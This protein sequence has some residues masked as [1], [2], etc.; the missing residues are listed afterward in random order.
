VLFSFGTD[1]VALGVDIGNAASLNQPIN[2]PIE[3]QFGG[4]VGIV[5]C[6][7]VRRSRAGVV[8]VVGP[9]V[10]MGSSRARRD[11]VATSRDGTFENRSGLALDAKM[12]SGLCCSVL[13]SAHDTGSQ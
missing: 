4:F 11:P 13:E 8:I 5:Y 12:D 9:V 3:T 7:N 10:M 2:L 6:G 1:S